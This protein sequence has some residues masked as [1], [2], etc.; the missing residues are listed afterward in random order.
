MSPTPNPIPDDELISAY[1]DGELNDADRARAEALLERDPESRQLL[2]DLRALSGTLRS[3]PQGSLGEDFPQ[4][5]LRAAEQAMLASP[6]LPAS[7]PV[8]VVPAAARRI[9]WRPRGARPWVYAG[10]AVAAGLVL[11]F[12]L[13]DEADRRVA[14]APEGAGAQ[15]KTAA[16]VR[17][18][19]MRAAPEAEGR[20]TPRGEALTAEDRG[21]S[22][23]GVT[24][25]GALRKDGSNLGN[26]RGAEPSNGGEAGMSRGAGALYGSESRADDERRSRDPNRD[27]VRAQLTNLGYATVAEPL[28]AQVATI[29]Q[30][31]PQPAA[32]GL[33]CVQVEV[34]PAAVTSGAFNRVLARQQIQVTPA[35]TSG[36]TMS[37]DQPL[38]RAA[39]DADK[40]ESLRD[41]TPAPADFFYVVATGEQLQ[42]AVVDMASQP[43]TFLSLDVQPAPQIPSQQPLQSYNRRAPSRA[44]GESSTSVVAGVKGNNSFGGGVHVTNQTGVAPPAVPPTAAPV[45]AT[46]GTVAKSGATPSGGDSL[47]RSDVEVKPSNPAQSAT[48]SPPA[49]DVRQQLSGERWVQSESSQREAT[50]GRA[51]Q[52]YWPEAAKSATDANT[53][54]DR[55]NA[56]KPQTPR[57]AAQ[58]TASAPPLALVTSTEVPAAVPIVGNSTEVEPSRPAEPNSGRERQP[59]AQVAT[60]LQSALF[61]VRVVTTPSGPVAES[62]AAGAAIAKDQVPADKAPPAES[63]PAK[64][65]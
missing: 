54:K 13:P 2:D 33:L 11:M 26:V 7:E 65:K 57:P 64:A 39:K 16:E 1:H 20:A 31:Q 9:G 25:G 55:G 23:E 5:V 12:V 14:L 3:A 28:A 17:R 62:P 58:P 38:S 10:L 30:L 27:L 44:L 50:Q 15:D 42:A 52:L 47:R 37:V 19:E 41:T 43:E 51:Q 6:D 63:A 35:A 8:P 18:P 49:S 22:S 45:P 29:D 60:E 32:L 56:E 21:A 34:S 48:A 24:V 59:V 36:S 46:A 61:V 53:P 4:R 40:V